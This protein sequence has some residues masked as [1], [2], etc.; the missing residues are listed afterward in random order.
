MLEVEIKFKL[1]DPKATGQ[2][3]HEL[4]FAVERKQEEHDSYFNAPDRDFA[5]TDEA[6]RI[7]QVG[8]NSILT[9]KGPKRGDQG[10]VRTEI[11]VP[12]AGDNSATLLR[13]ILIHLGYRPVRTVSKLRTFFR[14]SAQPELELTWDEV[15][16]LGTYLEMEIKADDHEGQEALQR[17]QALAKNLGLGEEERRS[18]LDL[19]LR[20]EGLEP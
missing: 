7:R 12:L 15:H 6:L 11:E 8:S 1:V 9:Y 17:L 10:K 20:C 5:Q 18:Y 2:R 13:E 3:L 19:L 14:H 16:G 4:G